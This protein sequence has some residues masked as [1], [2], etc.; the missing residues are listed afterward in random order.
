MSGVF[1]GIYCSL[2]TLYDQLVLSHVPNMHPNNEQ[3]VCFVEYPVKLHRNNM[4]L[5]TVLLYV[6]HSLQLIQQWLDT[7]AGSLRRIPQ[8][9]A[10]SAP[11]SPFV[12]PPELLSAQSLYF[13]L[14]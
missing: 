14:P 12:V 10:A 1:S 5:S 13:L 11:L 6:E 8:L 7:C 9:L 4:D 2:C 3:R